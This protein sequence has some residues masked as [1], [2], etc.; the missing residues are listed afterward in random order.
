MGEWPRVEYL[1]ENLVGGGRRQ[2]QFHITYDTCL[3]TEENHKTMKVENPDKNGIGNF[4]K[5]SKASVRCQ[6]LTAASMKMTVFWDVAL[7]SLVEVD[8]RFRSAYFL[9]DQSSSVTMTA[10][11]ME[12]VNTYETSVNLYESTRRNIPEG[13]HLLDLDHCRYTI[14]C[15]SVLETRAITSVRSHR[16]N[17]MPWWQGSRL[18]WTH[19]DS[20]LCF[21]AAPLPA[22]ESI[23]GRGST[24]SIH[25]WHRC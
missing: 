4:P 24:A 2:F 13:Y 3:E 19:A 11:I 22:M 25:S 16:G 1:S 18:K 5:R 14:C 15:S 10:L 21:F 9:R 12:A 8:G 23:G 6:V 7:C 20:K 17:A